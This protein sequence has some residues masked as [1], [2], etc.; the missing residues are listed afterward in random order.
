MEWVNCRSSGRRD[1]GRECRDEH[2]EAQHQDRP[3][4]GRAHPRE[5]QDQG[6]LGRPGR[7]L[8]ADGLRVAPRWGGGGSEGCKGRGNCQVLQ[9][10]LGIPF[11]DSKHCRCFCATFHHSHTGPLMPNVLNCIYGTNGLKFFVQDACDTAAISIL[12]SSLNNFNFN[13]NLF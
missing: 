11:N 2:P 8:Q 13:F 12:K 7:D 3:D 1:S 6:H 5:A 10:G 4:R 9:F